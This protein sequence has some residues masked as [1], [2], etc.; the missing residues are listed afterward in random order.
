MQE[1]IRNM[2]LEMKRLGM[3]RDRKSKQEYIEM[4]REAKKEVARPRTM[5][6]M[7]CMRAW[8]LRK[9]KRHWTDWRNR[10]TKRERTYNRSE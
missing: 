1:R 4:G 7:S 10:D 3:Q 8:T 2:R 5:H 9:E 6:M